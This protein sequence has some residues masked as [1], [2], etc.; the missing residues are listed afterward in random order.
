M[1]KCI[2]KAKASEKLKSHQDVRELE[3]HLAVVLR[4]YFILRLAQLS[5]DLD[6]SSSD[7]SYSDL[8][9]YWPQLSASPPE[10]PALSRGGSRKSVPASQ[11]LQLRSWGL[12]ASRTSFIFQGRRQLVSCTSKDDSA[13]YPW[14]EISRERVGQAA[15]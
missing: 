12:S 8:R 3:S 5:W 7:F 13:Q 15:R 6:T 4:N 2:E 1:S 9:H 11:P 14:A 10:D